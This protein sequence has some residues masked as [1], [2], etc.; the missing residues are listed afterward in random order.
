LHVPLL[1]EIQTGIRQAVVAG[2]EP[3]VAALL[4]GGQNPLK[5][6][7]I[8]RRHYETSLV[9]ALLGKFP[10]TVWLVGSPFV[11]EAAR[12][13]IREY[14][15]RKPCIAEYGEG[16]PECLSTRPAAERV[17]YL[18]DF[19]QLEWQVGQV[20]IAVGQ[21]AMPVDQLSAI[22][23]EAVPDAVMTMQTGLRYLHASWPV[24]ELMRLFLTDS[25]PDA[26]EFE[27]ADVWIE[28]R[29]ARGEFRMGRLTSGECVFRKS[30]VQSRSISEAAEAALD[31]DAGFDPGAALVKVVTEGLITGIKWH[32]EEAT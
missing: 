23:G 6:V 17:P 19:A 3:P 1:A 12:H 24:D 18:A 4:T 11:T 15:P 21:P 31:A 7:Q 2:G 8:H 25:A 9:T 16:F 5:R 32:S 26:L 22:P 30:I 20:S 27:P 29:G 14:P 28:I 13:F 10:A